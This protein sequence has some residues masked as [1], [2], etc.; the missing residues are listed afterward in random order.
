M[1]EIVSCFKA[2][3]NDKAQT[4]EKKN[5]EEKIISEEKFFEIVSCLITH[6]QTSVFMRMKIS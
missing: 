6:K 4:N 2:Q 3:T 1:F 5:P